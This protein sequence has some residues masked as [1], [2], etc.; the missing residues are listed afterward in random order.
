ML[1]NIRGLLETALH[2]TVKTI[3]IMTSEFDVEIPTG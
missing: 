2:T 3:I 1:H